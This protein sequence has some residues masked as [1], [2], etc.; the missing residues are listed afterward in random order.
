MR[1]VVQD[2]FGLVDWVSL[3]WHGDRVPAAE[4]RPVGGAIGERDERVGRRPPPL[5]VATPT[6]TVTFESDGAGRMALR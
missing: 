6:D 5:C 3:G 2:A 4:L 1:G